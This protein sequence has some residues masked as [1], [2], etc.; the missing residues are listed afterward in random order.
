MKELPKKAIKTKI[1]FGNCVIPSTSTES[2][3]KPPNGIENSLQF[4]PLLK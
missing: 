3:T 2:W 4:T 1:C